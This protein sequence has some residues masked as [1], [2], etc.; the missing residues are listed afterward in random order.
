[1]VRLL[2]LFCTAV[3]AVF[4]AQ[5]AAMADTTISGSLSAA[6]P[7]DLQPLQETESKACMQMILPI[8]GRLTITATQGRRI[9]IP[10]SRSGR[11]STK[12]RSGTYTFKLTKARVNGSETTVPAG[13]L[14][15]TYSKVTVGNR[16]LTL[17][18]GVIH[19]SYLVS[20]Q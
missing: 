1:M 15:L 4:S 7:C 18:L 2:S 6:S 11:F 13:D 5:P 10:V 19:K 17:N 3:I 14:H 8:Q 20:L 12:L 16:P 9:T